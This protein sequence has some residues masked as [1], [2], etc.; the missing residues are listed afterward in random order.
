[1]LIPKFPALASFA[2]MFFA[3]LCL[4]AS[5]AAV[6][7]SAQGA[8]WGHLRGPFSF[9]SQ[10]RERRDFDAEE[11]EELCY[12]S[13]VTSPVLYGR[14]TYRQAPRCSCSVS[15]IDTLRSPRS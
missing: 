1:M 9:E 13:C 7:P 10:L 6:P 12:R 3:I 14:W 2:R 11:R 5:V 4:S 15:P 8:T